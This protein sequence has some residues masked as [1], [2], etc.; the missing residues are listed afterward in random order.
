MSTEPRHSE[1][2]GEASAAAGHAGAAQPSTVG[3]VI[4]RL[5]PVGILAAISVT[6][7]ALGGLLLF[8]Y[9]DPIGAWLAAQPELGLWIYV[10]GFILLA[11]LALAPTHVQALLAGYVFHFALGVPAALAGFSGA[12]LLGYVIAR[13]VSGERAVRIIAEQPKWKA[14]YDALLGAGWW[15]TLGIVTLLRIPPNSPFALTNLVLA[16]TRVPPIAYLL[17]TAVGM[18]PRTVM[19]VYVGAQLKSLNDSGKPGWYIW[20]GVGLTLAVLAVLGHIISRALE[21]VRKSMLA[22]GA[23][24][25]DPNVQTA[26]APR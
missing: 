21:G 10:G 8:Y 15:R 4:R 16:A 20:V 6:L 11:G 22:A 7:P 14:V 17:A 9:R 5:G 2:R 26:D 25:A 1:R 3:T 18:A 23:A 13:T 12:S 19:V 24:P